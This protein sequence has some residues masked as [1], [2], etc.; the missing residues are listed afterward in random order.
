MSAPVVD[1]AE[2]TGQSDLLLPSRRR[3]GTGLRIRSLGTDVGRAR[4][5][6]SRSGR[7]W[8]MKPSTLA[9]AEPSSS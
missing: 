2:V 1:Q 3:S 9:N 6:L 4:N 8:I 5:A 7:R